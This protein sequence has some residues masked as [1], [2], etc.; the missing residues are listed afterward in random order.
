MPT[1][2]DGAVRPLLY[3]AG[4]EALRLFQQTG[5]LQ[6]SDGSPVTE[7]DRRSEKILVRGLR[8]HHPADAIHSE[9]GL[10]TETGD[11]QWFVDPLDGTSSFLEGLA[12]WGPTLGLLEDGQPV[13]GAL[14]LPRTGDYFH[15]ESGSAWWND[16]PLAPLSTDA[17]TK[18]SIVYIPSRLH[19]HARLDWPGKARNLGSIS[20]H[21]ALVATGSAS[22][23]LIP[24]GWQ[25]W[26]LACGLAMMA[27][28]G[29][30]ICTLDGQPF[31]MEHHRR[32]P[33]W[34]GAPGVI[35]WMLT[36]PR[37]QLFPDS[38]LSSPTSQRI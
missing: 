27:A 17:P 20:A 28:V 23:V 6:K 32:Q 4:K 25:P 11:R 35:S 29:G 18:R 22:L 24:G 8:H 3:E 26:D 15:A 36:Q 12:H 33:I 37:L 10:L 21:M 1:P 30:R 14:Y 5:E 16:A 7:A 19:A 31:S 13:Y 38:P 34:A 9:E 2:Y